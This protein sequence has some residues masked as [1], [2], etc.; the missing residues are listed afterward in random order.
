MQL[1]II[2]RKSRRRERHPSSDDTVPWTDR[3]ATAAAAAAVGATDTA[4]TPWSVVTFV[5]TG[6]TRAA[7]ARR[8]MTV[9]VVGHHSVV[10][11]ENQVEKRS[12]FL[13]WFVFGGKRR[14]E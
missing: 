6:A 5:A 12:L 9:G 7:I 4:S 10:L 2:G 8:A 13:V 14:K 3:R 1:N 11:D